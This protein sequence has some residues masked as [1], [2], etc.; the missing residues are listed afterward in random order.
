MDLNEEAN[1][2][3]RWPVLA[4]LVDAV[5]D[6]GAV[7]YKEVAIPLLLEMLKKQAGL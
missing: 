3:Q 1:G 7:A 4:K 6:T 5:R 2:P